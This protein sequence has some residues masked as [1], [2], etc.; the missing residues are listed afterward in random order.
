MPP[1]TERFNLSVTTTSGDLHAQ[2][3]VPT[4]FIAI[5]DIVPVVR[6]LGE[7]AQDLEVARTIQAGKSISCQKGCAA[8]C[9]I[10]IPVS[11][12]EAF[13]LVDVVKSLPEVHQARIQRKLTDTRTQLHNAGLLPTLQGLAESTQP[14]SD[15]DLEPVNQAYYALRLPCIFLEEETCSIY[16]HRPAACRG[17]LVSSPPE[18]CQDM[19]TNPVEGLH[20]PVRAG[21][22]LSILWAELTGEPLR[23]LP[24]P[25]ALEWAEKHQDLKQKA[26]KGMDLLSRTLDGLQKFLQQ[27]FTSFSKKPPIPD[28]GPSLTEKFEAWP[29]R[30]TEKHS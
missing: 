25:M 20:V 14:Q 28:H 18:M 29:K 26:W 10:M 15:E 17:H 11:P 19:E 24:L 4:G 23:L 27:T 9:R 22:V 16:E 6:S 13:A 21:T 12:P 5:T 3:E 2:V 8:C 7:Q 30:P 1:Q